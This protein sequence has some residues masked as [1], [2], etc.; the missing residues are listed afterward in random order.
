MTFASTDA[1]AVVCAYGVV[2][3]GSAKAR[4]AVVVPKPAVVC[5]S[6]AVNGVKAGRCT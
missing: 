1:N 6:V 5:R 3:D 4:G 2:R